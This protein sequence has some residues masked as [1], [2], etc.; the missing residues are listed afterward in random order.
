MSGSPKVNG[1][2]GLKGDLFRRL[3][4]GDVVYPPSR[5]DEEDDNFDDDGILPIHWRTFYRYISEFCRDGHAIRRDI[6]LGGY[7]MI[8]GPVEED[9]DIVN[10]TLTMSQ[11][12]LLL[13]VVEEYGGGSALSPLSPLGKISESI[14]AAIQGDDFYSERF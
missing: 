8:K 6:R 12:T 5:H 2:R 9:D 13:E 7:V 14:E 3:A 1:Y 11:A 4:T 10:V